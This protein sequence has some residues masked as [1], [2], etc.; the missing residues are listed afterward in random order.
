MVVPTWLLIVLIV[1]AVL[2]IGGYIAR[3]RQLARTER[4]FHGVMPYHDGRPVSW[5]Y[6]LV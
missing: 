4:Q 6:S 5:S 3:R 1:L 2:V